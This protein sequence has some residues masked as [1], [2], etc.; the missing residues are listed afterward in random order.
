MADEKSQRL[1]LTVVTRERKVLEAEVDEVVLPAY[2]GYLGVLPGH[3]P[4]L[5]ALRVGTMTYRQGGKEEHLVIR[6]GFAEV[7]PNRVIVL[8][9]GATRPSE[10][11]VATAERM[12]AEAEA[13]LADLASHDEGF[14]TAQ[15][16]LE[17]SVSMISLARRG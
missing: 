15:A 10:I 5:A 2:H 14:N 9:E 12:K 7:L 16:K 3:T 11:D 8:A 17:E 1:S 4:L 6:W 13:E